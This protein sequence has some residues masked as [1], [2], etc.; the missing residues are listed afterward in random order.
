MKLKYTRN[1]YSWRFEGNWSTVFNQSNINFFVS[2]YIYK[3]RLLSHF[4]SYS[5][6][7]GTVLHKGFKTANKYRI[8]MSIFI[9]V[10]FANVFS[11]NFLHSFR[12]SSELSILSNAC[13]FL[14]GNLHIHIY[15]ANQDRSSKGTC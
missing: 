9:S 11:V 6:D 12:L 1:E 3:S 14:T 15:R 7:H 13:I 5:S 8:L 2:L 10:D 4:F